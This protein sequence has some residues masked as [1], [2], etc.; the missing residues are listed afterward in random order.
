LSL[1]R[2]WEERGVG[3]WADRGGGKKEEAKGWDFD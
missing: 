2:S 1:G 3:E